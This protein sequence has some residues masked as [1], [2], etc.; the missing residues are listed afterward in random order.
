MAERQW[1]EVDLQG[2]LIGRWKL[3]PRDGGG[4]AY[5]A[6]A[7]LYTVTHQPPNGVPTLQIFDRSTASWK[8]VENMLPA[9]PQYGRVS[10]LIGA[11][12][13]S[14]VASVD[15]IGGIRLLWLPVNP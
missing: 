11:E 6:N 2:N 5:T 10:F 13:N 14:V 8:P 12:R 4:L 9:T 15:P 1:L 3:G 7:G